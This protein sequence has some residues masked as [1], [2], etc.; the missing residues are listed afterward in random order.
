MNVDAAPTDPTKDEVWRNLLD[1]ARLARCYDTLATIYGW[2]RSICRIVLA[3]AGL[4]LSGAVTGTPILSQVAVPFAVLLAVFTAIDLTA[5]LSNKRRV[6]GR[7]ATRYAVLE[8]EW[9]ELRSLTDLHAISDEEAR[10]RVKA[11]VEQGQ[12]LNERADNVGVV[13]WKWLNLRCDKQARQL[14]DPQAL[15]E[16]NPQ[17]LIEAN[18]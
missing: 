5:N 2:S 13:T 16:T 11:L 3:T 4:G 8:G 6:L 15:I 14:Y 10:E 9:R 18:V 17:V 7:I 1:A 12:K